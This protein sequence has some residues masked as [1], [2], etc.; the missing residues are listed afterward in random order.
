MKIA[1][2]LNIEEDIFIL[3]GRYVKLF[4]FKTQSCVSKVAVC[5]F[6]MIHQAAF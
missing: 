3:T 2:S 1:P 4:I 6:A 5:R